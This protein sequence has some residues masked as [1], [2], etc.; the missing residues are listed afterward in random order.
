MSAVSFDHMGWLLCDGRSL[1]VAD[2]NLLFQVI[3]YAFTGST[4]GTTFKL[5][6]ARGRV[7]A[8]IGQASGTSGNTWELGDISGQETH[9]LTI[10]QMPSHNH[11]TNASDTVVGNNQTGTSTTGIT[12]QPHTHTYFNQANNQSTD[13]AFSTETAADN[14]SVNQTTGSTTVAINDPGHYHSIATQGGDDPHNNIQPTIWMG[15]TFIFCGIF[16][17]GSYPLTNGTNI[18]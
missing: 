10:A 6:D 17:A 15:N 1:S 7:A 8:S 5:P 9:T 14:A 12:T 18:L 11:G 3:G 2:Y 13:N 4:G 16:T